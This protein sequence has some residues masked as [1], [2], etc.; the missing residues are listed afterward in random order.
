VD[1][2][3]TVERPIRDYRTTTAAFEVSGVCTLTALTIGLDLEHSFVGDLRLSVLAPS[4]AEVVLREHT[5]AGQAH[6]VSSYDPSTVPALAPLLGTSGVGHWEVRVRDDAGADTGVFH[7]ASL[8]LG[9][10]EGSGA[11]A[12]GAHPPAGPPS[13]RR[14]EPRGRDR[15]LPSGPAPSGPVRPSG[16]GV[17][18]PWVSVPTPLPPTS[19]GRR[20]NGRSPATP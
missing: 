19:G 14:T 7:T 8:R 12:S 18:S 17:V 6:L 9:C 16:P 2:D 10:A 11:R 13:S 1:A 3:L 15:P 20:T 4:G 5:G